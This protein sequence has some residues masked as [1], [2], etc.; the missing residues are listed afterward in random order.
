[1]V[2]DFREAVLVA[3]A[4]HDLDLDMLVKSLLVREDCVAA[5]AVEVWGMLSE[6]V[7]FTREAKDTLEASVVRLRVQ[8]LERAG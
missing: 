1:M 6:E 8:L 4:S 5:L 3:W 2:G 7:C